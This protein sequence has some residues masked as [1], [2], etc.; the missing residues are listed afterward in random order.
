MERQA[1]SVEQMAVYGT[2]SISLS[3]DG[4]PLPERIPYAE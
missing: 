4:G 2:D 3:G 1:P